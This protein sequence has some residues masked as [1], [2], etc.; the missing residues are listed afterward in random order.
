M[1]LR[2][3]LILAVFVAAP[4]LAADPAPPPDRISTLVV[5]GNDACPRSTEGEIVVCAREP[6]SER[7]R[8]P[9]RFRGHKPLP[10]EGSW[11]ANAVSC[12][13]IPNSCAPVGSGGQSGCMAQF[14][15]QARAQREADKAEAAEVP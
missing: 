5:Y 4:C 15:A 7:Y 14:L 2:L 11:A 13:G 9:K 6:E 8:V 1:S 10:A 12:M 3:A